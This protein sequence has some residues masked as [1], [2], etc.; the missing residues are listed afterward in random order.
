M[1]SCRA[2]VFR[3]S[4]SSLEAASLAK[5]ALEYRCSVKWPFLVR[6]PCPCNSV[7]ILWTVCISGVLAASL[8]S[9][10]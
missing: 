3:V 1:P 8:A 2:S 4:Q 6:H 10:A 5:F 9:I 7:I